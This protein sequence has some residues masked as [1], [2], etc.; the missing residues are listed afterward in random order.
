ME[1]GAMYVARAGRHVI[2]VDAPDAD[3][4]ARLAEVL[5]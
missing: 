4:L 1:T 2:L 3:T 5:P